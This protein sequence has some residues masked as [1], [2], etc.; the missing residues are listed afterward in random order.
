M[1]AGQL[2]FDYNTIAY[3]D[4]GIGP[5]QSIYAQVWYRDPAIDP[6]GDGFTDAIAGLLT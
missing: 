5:G 2:V 4:P 6:F 1:N 3:G